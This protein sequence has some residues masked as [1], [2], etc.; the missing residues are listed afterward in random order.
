[1]TLSEQ[2]DAVGLTADEIAHLAESARPIY[3]DETLFEDDVT[4]P[5]V[6]LSQTREKVIEERCRRSLAQF[7]KRSW[8]VLEPSTPLRWNWH[9]E[10]VCNHIQTM[11]ED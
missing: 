3:V 9:I 10:V 6:A 4:D 7:F 1:M 2:F 5:R 8:S 11:L